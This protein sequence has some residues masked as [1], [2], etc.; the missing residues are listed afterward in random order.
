[1]RLGGFFAALRRLRGSRGNFTASCGGGKRPARDRSTARH[2]YHAAALRCGAQRSPY[3]ASSF[4]GGIFF[5]P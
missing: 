1:L 4:G 5:K 3:I 2:K